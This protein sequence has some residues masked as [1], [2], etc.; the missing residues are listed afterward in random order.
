MRRAFDVC[1]AMLRQAL[2]PDMVSYSALISACEKGDE[3]RWAFD[4][5]V[6][7]LRQALQPNM[8]GTGRHGRGP[9]GVPPLPWRPKYDSGLSQRSIAGRLGAMVK[10]SP[11]KAFRIVG[12]SPE[13]LWPL[14]ASQGSG[15]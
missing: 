2:E 1:V 9:Q 5:C 15:T 3:L 13:R 6:A 10:N 4:V 11:S 12:P 7:M 8:V 14:L